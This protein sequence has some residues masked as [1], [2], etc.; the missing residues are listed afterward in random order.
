MLDCTY[1]WFSVETSSTYNIGKN[2][3]TEAI[4]FFTQMLL[5]ISN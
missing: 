1:V 2:K 5:K 3:K 4:S